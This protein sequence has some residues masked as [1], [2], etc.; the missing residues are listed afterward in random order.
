MDRL[1]STDLPAT[2][3]AMLFR[4]AGLKEDH[5]DKKEIEVTEEDGRI[6]LATAKRMLKWLAE[7][8]GRGLELSPSNE[9]PKDVQKLTGKGYRAALEHMN[10]I[11]DALGKHRRQP[12]TVEELAA[13][14]NVD[15]EEI[16]RALSTATK[17]K[18]A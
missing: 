15:P 13:Y 12:V 5:N 3:K 17:R 7:G 11:R 8:V 16:R 4:I 1:D 10:E 6:S 14:D 2:Q 18:A 9:T